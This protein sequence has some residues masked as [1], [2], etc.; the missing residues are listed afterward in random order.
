MIVRGQRDG[1][2][3]RDKQRNIHTSSFLYWKSTMDPSSNKLRVF[4][5]QSL[6]KWL[7]FMHKSKNWWKK[8]ER[9]NPICY[10]GW[11]NHNEQKGTTEYILLSHN[12]NIICRVWTWQNSKITDTTQY[13]PSPQTEHYY[14]TTTYYSTS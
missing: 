4:G 12:D 5:T 2:C 7:E 3:W 11:N 6:W 1:K 13:V 8:E 10:S 9:Q 14:P